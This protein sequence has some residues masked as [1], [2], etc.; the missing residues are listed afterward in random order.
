M[1]AI[2]TIDMDL[3]DAVIDAATTEIS[4]CDATFN[5]WEGCSKTEA[6]S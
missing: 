2:E 5:A 4:W 3:P 6:R 1:T